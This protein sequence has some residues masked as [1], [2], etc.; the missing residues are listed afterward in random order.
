MAEGSFIS[1]R[2]TLREPSLSCVIITANNAR[3][4]DKGEY[5]GRSRKHYTDH[6]R[7]LLYE[8]SCSLNHSRRTANF[9][10]V[11]RPVHIVTLGVWLQCVPY[12]F[13]PTDIFVLLVLARPGSVIL[14][15]NHSLS[16][17]KAV[18]L[19]AYSVTA[20]PRACRQMVVC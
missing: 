9:Y 4:G 18:S 10:G 13:Y 1:T 17:K 14:L 16:V 2:C 3:L 20:P 7:F 5:F 11:V 12:P 19:G 8:A 15:G 6:I